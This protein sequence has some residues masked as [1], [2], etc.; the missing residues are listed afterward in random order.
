MICSKKFFH[1]DAFR[2]Q[3]L[4]YI[5]DVEAPSPVIAVSTITDLRLVL[6]YK[7]RLEIRNTQL[8]LLRHFDCN[9]FEVLDAVVTSEQLLVIL[10]QVQTSDLYEVRMMNAELKGMKTAFI[11]NI[12]RPRD[13]LFKPHIYCSNKR[14]IITD[15]FTRKLYMYDFKG[16]ALH[17]LDLS[18]SPYTLAIIDK[19][20]L[21]ANNDYNTYKVASKSFGNLSVEMCQPK[22]PGFDF[23]ANQKSESL[24]PSNAFSQHNSGCPASSHQ[25]ASFTKQTSGFSLLPLPKSKNSLITTTPQF[26]STF[27][28]NKPFA[29]PSKHSTTSS[30]TTSGLFHQ[31]RCTFSKAKDE[32]GFYYLAECQGFGEK[33]E[34][35]ISVF[36]NAGIP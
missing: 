34:V 23:I 36:S 15:F 1:L 26:S 5:Q 33:E 13:S 10:V 24:L 14:I 8:E 30:K 18:I 20:T 9:G 2:P 25:A 21:L 7:N 17:R 31:T 28:V 12:E 3:H 27:S 19:Y 22:M 32:F 4:D 6:A 35:I 16:Q 29:N 11:T